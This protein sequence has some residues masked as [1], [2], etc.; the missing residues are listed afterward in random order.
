M[1]P[2]GKGLVTLD[3]YSV[4]DEAECLEDQVQFMI[5][6]GS[7]GNSIPENVRSP[8]RPQPP[9]IS[10]EDGEMTFSIG[11]MVPAADQSGPGALSVGARSQLRA[12][13]WIDGLNPDAPLS[14]DV[15]ADAE[16]A[17]VAPAAALDAERS[18][19]PGSPLVDAPVPPISDDLPGRFDPE[20]LQGSTSESSP[21]RGLPGAPPALPQGA[22]A[23]NIPQEPTGASKKTPEGAHPSA[24]LPAPSL[25]M[26][27]A[28][29]SQPETGAIVTP[30]G[31]RAALALGT[32]DDAA[33][34]PEPR[35]Q[36]PS[37]QAMTGTNEAPGE[38]PPRVLR[39]DMAVARPTPLL[40]TQ[41][42][43]SDM[44]ADVAQGSDLFVSK[45]TTE[46]LLQ[47]PRLSPAAPAPSDGSETVLSGTRVP[48]DRIGP[49][50]KA[51]FATQIDQPKSG[52]SAILTGLDNPGTQDNGLTAES[53]G[54]DDSGVLDRPAA[55]KT[56]DALAFREAQASREVPVLAPAASSPKGMTRNADVS[57]TSRSPAEG[58]GALI[59]KAP[60]AE[61]V[62]G[63][64]TSAD[65]SAQAASDVF[66]DTMDAGQPGQSSLG[67]SLRRSPE[68][69]IRTA[70][71][72]RGAT[73]QI[74]EAV[75]LP[76]DGSIEVRL[77]PEE[78]GR[79]RVSMIPGEAGLVIQLVAERPETLEL[80]RRHADLLAADLQDAGYTGLEF[81]FSR[82]DRGHDPS[83]TGPGPRTDPT[84]EKT[85]M[86]PA[87]P[88]GVA[89]SVADGTLDLR[90]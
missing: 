67:D 71:L 87:A 8:I 29:L 39:S 34:M 12:D 3:L 53:V 10:T 49:D 85:A 47:D 66:L 59:S 75:R 17:Q 43:V 5:F 27:A 62:S 60:I 52:P 31:T 50:S 22:L 42:M 77:S 80:L 69:E 23:I 20:P 45:P 84:I 82:E 46:S 33:E 24:P 55:I 74:A 7:A 1:Q 21:P 83:D 35:I 14:V 76:L 88:Q 32:P 18:L 65:P 30:P 36:W 2:T 25:A 37:G 86:Q 89:R 11:T 61:V 16:T 72:A 70:T 68:P 78:L 13:F 40:G 28:S 57:H 81:S 4:P 26:T 41:A 44:S 9:G 15:A 38:G 48:A 19:R 63:I 64:Q 58:A 51:P 79:V 6:A 90:L 56:G 54:K 73:A